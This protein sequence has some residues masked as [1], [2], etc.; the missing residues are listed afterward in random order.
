MRKT[1]NSLLTSYLLTVILKL[2]F[3]SIKK[4]LHTKFEQFKKNIQRKKIDNLITYFTVH[5][6]NSREIQKIFDN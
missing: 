4:R 1:L 6:F 2:I 3:E 5:A